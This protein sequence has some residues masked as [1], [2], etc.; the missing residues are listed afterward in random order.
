MNF[1]LGIFLATVFLIAALIV[2]ATKFLFPYHRVVALIIYAIGWIPFLYSVF[3][4]KKWLLEH[5]EAATSFLAAFWVHIV[6]G[7]VA[8]VVLYFFFVIFPVAKSPFLKLGDAEISQRLKED[9]TLVLY[10][11]DRLASSLSSALDQDIFSVD[12]KNISGGEK[13]N[14]QDFWVSYIETLVELDLLKERYKTF[15]QINVV[16]KNA[17][18]KRAF[19]NGYASFLA[20]HYY[21]LQ[22]SKAI[23]DRGVITFLNESFPSYGIDKEMYDS[24]QRKLTD[25]NEL[26]RLNAGRAYHAL[27]QDTD[28]AMEALINR[29][30]EEVDASLDSY[31]RLIADKPL[32]FLEKNSF[33]LWFPIQRQSAINISYI[34]TTG[35]DYHIGADQIRQFRDLF[36]PGDILLQRREWHATNVGIPGYWTHSA[37]YMGTLEKMNS[38]FEGLSLLDGKSF[39]TFIKENYPEAYNKL[40]ELD[41]GGYNY[42][43]IESKRPG[44]ILMSLEES[45]HADSLAVLRVKSTNRQDHFKVVTQALTHLGKPYDFNFNFIT[46][47]ALV[48]SELV[49]KAFQD[50]SKLNLTLREFNGRPIVSPNQFAEKFA[51]DLESG[52]SELELVLFLDGNEK[53]GKATKKGEA[54][55]K[56]TWERPKWHIAKDFVSFE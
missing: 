31:A 23:K 12:F 38:Y 37:L 5:Q 11:N 6:F 9:Q 46:D 55:F 26:I 10:L 43:V 54:V 50:T 8:L 48:C 42:S 13:K 40:K 56:E 49:Y 17:L 53:T 51:R 45:A 4:R 7:V 33:K 18:H 16:T 29:H 28:P 21:M 2:L 41:A 44:V 30:M 34:R 22:L 27:L 24:L 32:K 15:Y 39:E 36:V 19:I 20:Q 35:R 47:N 1:W 25:A 14:L 52:V 3:L